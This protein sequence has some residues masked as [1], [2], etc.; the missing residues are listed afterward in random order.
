MLA[1]AWAAR[2]LAMRLYGVAIHDPFTILLFPL[3]LLTV[4]ALACLIAA[5]R[6][7]EIH[8]D[9]TIGRRP[10]LATGSWRMNPGARARSSQLVVQQLV[11]QRSSFRVRRSLL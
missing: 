1:S 4:G 7:A 6:G 11:A 10:A 3:M 8:R 9:R 2:L 5:R